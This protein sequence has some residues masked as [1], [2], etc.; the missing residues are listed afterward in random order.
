MLEK[1]DCLQ[2]RV[3]RNLTFFIMKILCIFFLA[4]IINLSFVKKNN[5]E[6]CIKNI[7]KKDITKI[8]F[9]YTRVGGIQS[10]KELLIWINAFIP[11]D[12]ANQTTKI[13]G[14]GPYF[15]RTAL[16]FMESY[17]LADQRTFNSDVNASHRM[18]SVVKI[19]FLDESILGNSNCNPTIRLT[20][21]FIESCHSTASST[22]MQITNMEVKPTL[23]GKMGYYFSLKAGSKNPCVEYIPD[24]FV[25]EINWAIN[26]VIIN[27][28][29]TGRIYAT[30]EGIIEPFPAFEMY[31]SLDNNKPVTI[32]TQ[33]I[34]TIANPYFLP[35]LPLGYSMPADVIV[36]SFSKEIF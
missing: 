14:P 7:S 24:A 20:N 18:Q 19:D 29:S 1:S 8:N 11:K 17:F 27:D 28:T 9:Q 5:K 34:G 3:K 22:N 21:G 31:A 12:I 32:F 30:L 4:L 2:D 35:N 26:V 36:S 33:S 10:P 6:N 15:G 23:D 13:Q 16:S 25:P